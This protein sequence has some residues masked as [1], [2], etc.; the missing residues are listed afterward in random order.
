VTDDT[1]DA[2]QAMILRTE[3]ATVPPD[4]TDAWLD[5]NA[6]PGDT[7]I[8]V[9]PD[10]EATQRYIDADGKSGRRFAMT[11]DT[12]DWEL[13]PDDDGVRVT[14]ATDGGDTSAGSSGVAGRVLDGLAG[15]A[16]LSAAGALA[17]FVAGTDA[18]AEVLR[19]FSVVAWA[20]TFVAFAIVLAWRRVGTG[21][22]TAGTGGGS[23]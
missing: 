21:V 23:A 13:V 8:T 2:G 4:E 11:V 10:G 9:H 5:A 6:E 3:T 16:T 18:P 22:P 7:I 19:T 17:L 14:R 20:L 15:A 1:L 12:S